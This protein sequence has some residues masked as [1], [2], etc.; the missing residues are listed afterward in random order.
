MPKIN[1]LESLKVFKS[2]VECGSFTAAAKQLDVSTAW[3]SKSIERLEVRLGITLFQRSTRQMR[4]TK[5]GEHCYAR[6]LLLLNQWQELEEDLA[7][8][9]ESPTGKLRI[10]V[11]MSWGL[12]QFGAV[13]TAFMEQYPEIMLDIRLSDRHV[14][15]LEEKYDLVLRLTYQ[16]SD[17]S[18][19]CR[20]ITSYRRVACAAPAYLERHGEPQHPQEL[21]SYAC[22]MYTL[23]GMPK[24]WQFTKGRQLVDTYLEPRLVSNNS[25]LLHSALLAGHGI[26]LI[27]EFIVAK[28][29]QERRLIPILQD[30]ETPVLNLYSLRAANK[31]TSYRLKLL[32]NFLCVRLGGTDN[33]TAPE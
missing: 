26:A 15:V 5:N 22:L 1:Q 25:I 7:Q 17:S 32:H 3:V 18:L 31:R 24:K 12:S 27:P 30:F 28:D 20:K 13:L 11:P 9:H 33:L 14:N 8:S 19:L 21:N 6:G 2:V 16:L 4:I 29:L 10:S 23:P